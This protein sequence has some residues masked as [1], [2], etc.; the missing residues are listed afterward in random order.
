[1]LTELDVISEDKRLVKPDLQCRDNVD[2]FALTVETGA[3]V[4]AV[5]QGLATTTFVTFV[6][7][8]P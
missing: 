7:V 2:G 5:Q 3:A 6:V 4:S 1:M 8:N